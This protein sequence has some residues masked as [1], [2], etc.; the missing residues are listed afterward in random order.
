MEVCV[1]MNISEQIECTCNVLPIKY[2]ILR[3]RL[4]VIILV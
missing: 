4:N 2:I 1:F 3:G